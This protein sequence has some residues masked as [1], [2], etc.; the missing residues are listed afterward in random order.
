MPTAESAP[1]A[2]LSVTTSGFGDTTRTTLTF[3]I[4]PRLSG[5]FRYSALRNLP[6]TGSVDDTFYDRSFDLRYQI[7]T[8]TNNRPAV[9]IG[10][11]D[12]IGTGL[13]GGEYIVAT[14]ELVP[15]LRV[16][17]GLGWGRLGSANALGSTG[18]RPEELLEEGG[19]PTYD[20]WFRGSM[21]RSAGS[22]TRRT[23]S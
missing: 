19:V 6:I 14:K 8:E 3:Q 15:G 13:Y 5:S 11:Q 9:T 18:D 4:T 1:D 2:T 12:F 7:L 10:L 16:T 17:G 21:P 22:R 23:T 20:R